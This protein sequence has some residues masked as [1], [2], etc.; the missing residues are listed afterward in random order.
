M[1]TRA[2]RTA[3][4][5][6]IIA[7]VA[8]TMPES[9]K[10]SKYRRTFERPDTLCLD[11]AAYF[12]ADTSAGRHVYVRIRADYPT[13]ITGALSAGI[14]AW[15]RSN[16][17][18]GFAT[19]PD[20]MNAHAV[21]DYYGNCRYDDSAVRGCDA[22]NDHYDAECRKLCNRRGYVTFTFSLVQC[23]GGAPGLTKMYGATFRRSDGH[24]FGWDLLADTTS[25]KLHSM[26]REGVRRYFRDKLQEESVSDD[27][28][29]SLLAGVPAHIDAADMLRHFP[30]PQMPPY[31]SR[32]GMTFVYQPYEIAPYSLGA[33]HFTVPFKD[34]EPYMSKQARRL[35]RKQKK[36]E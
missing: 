21:V 4:A 32:Y 7:A 13:P 2:I 20:T 25:R 26:M 6:A 5:A 30:M 19:P 10:N 11:S 12:K 24:R 9:C 29:R 35:L 34:V 3:L 18:G 22:P 23:A 31:M 8:F 15:V 27:D 33:P 17:G 28:L 1:K 36:E 16:I 14:A